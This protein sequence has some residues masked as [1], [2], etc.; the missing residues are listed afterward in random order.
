MFLFFH[1]FVRSVNAIVLLCL[2]TTKNV[3]K[4]ANNIL[5]N[6]PNSG[7]IPKLYVTS[8]VPWTVSCYILPREVENCIVENKSDLGTK[9]GWTFV[10]WHEI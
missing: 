8:K 2:Q 3:Q 1:K 9:K 10:F 7:I 5:T 6:V 4:N